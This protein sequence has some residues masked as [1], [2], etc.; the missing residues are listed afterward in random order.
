MTQETETPAE[1]AKEA[2][3]DVPVSGILDILQNKTGQLLDPSRNG[4][5]KPSDPFIPRELIKRFKLKKGNFVEA[6]AQHNDRFLN[7]KVHFIEKVDGIA[8]E[9]R[10]GLYSFQQLVSI[11][12]D[13]QLRLEAKDGRVTTR[14]MDLF[15]PIGKGTRGLIVAPPRTG[16]TTLLHDIA[17]GLIE[18]HSECHVIVL[19]VDE[20]P[21]EVTDFKRSV[22]AEIYASS[23]DEELENHLRLAELAIERA[24]RLVESGKDVVF[25]LDSITR[26][27]RAYNAAS[28]KGGR[29]MTGGLDVRALE[30]PRQLFSAARNCEE[31][32]SLTIIATALVETGS[33]MDELIFQEFKGT[34]NMEMVLD[35]KA[36]ELR[37]WPAINLNASGTRKEELIL[38]GKYLEGAQFLRRALAGQKIEDAAE[39]MI[40]RFS[41]TKNNDEFLKLLQR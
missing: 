21:E 30:K 12:P 40:E 39:A 6:K 5:T 31:G 18:N 14:I 11:T 3:D 38:A 19:L 35:R 22:D 32:G 7:P 28:G 10:K 33:K 23:N 36:A 37:L 34:G 17:H 4:K 1:P 41:Q 29:T 9:D 24:K 8:L 26:L 15:C 16:K 25:L 2:K 27:A 13:E 20:R